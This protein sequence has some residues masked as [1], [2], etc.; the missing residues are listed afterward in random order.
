MLVG[1]AFSLRRLLAVGLC[2]LPWLPCGLPLPGLP[3]AALVVRLPLPPAAV[4]LP[5]DQLADRLPDELPVV[6]RAAD[7]RRQVGGDARERVLLPQGDQQPLEDLHHEILGKHTVAIC[8]HRRQRG[9]GTAHAVVDPPPHELLDV[10]QVL[11]RR[12]LQVR[13][14]HRR[15]QRLVQRRPIRCRQA[16]VHLAPHLV[17]REHRR[18]NVPHGLLEHA[19]LDGI[20]VLH[21]HDVLHRLRVHA[22]PLRRVQNIHAC[23]SQDRHQINVVKPLRLVA[24][25]REPSHGPLNQLL[26]ELVPLH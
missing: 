8:V 15:G 25:V 2:F 14:R 21:S 5:R 19:P 3:I 13:P 1:I 26:D 17:F 11:L 10:P 7:A 4:G 12:P 16:L 23:R 6:R 20:V 9:P 18:G 24:G 22:Y